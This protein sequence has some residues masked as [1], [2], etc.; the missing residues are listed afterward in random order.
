MNWLLSL[1]MISIVSL[2]YAQGDEMTLNVST[3][4]PSFVVDL[5]ANP[6]TGYQ[7]SVVDY[8][9]ELLTLSDSVY[10]Q[11][12]PALIGSG[13]H[14]RY[15]FKLNKGKKYPDSTQINFKYARAWE[16]NNTGMLKQVIVHFNPN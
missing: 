14:M 2:G 1:L 5:E 12:R 6:T 7:W 9:K 16:K 13:G 4:E 3:K 11:S 15:T 10:T 8:D